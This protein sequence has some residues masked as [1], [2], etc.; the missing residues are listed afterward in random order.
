MEAGKLNQKIQLLKFEQL[1]SATGQKTK[2]QYVPWKKPLWA[3]VLCTQSTQTDENG[4][5]VTITVY[6]F[7]IR[8]RDGIMPNM[9]ILWKGR[10]FELT[11]APVDWKNETTGLTLL[12]REV[13]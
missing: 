3:Q 9:R 12:A 1:P 11:G 5:L 10:C 7:Y 2:G 13:L 8:R 6:R 4:A